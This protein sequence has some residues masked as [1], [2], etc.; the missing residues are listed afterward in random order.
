MSH[1]PPLSLES[2]GSWEKQDQFEDRGLVLRLPRFGFV[3]PG[4]DG[5]RGGETPEAA[6]V[7]RLGLS[8]P[9]LP[10]HSPPPLSLI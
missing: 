9:S 3:G 2:E 7:M 6:Y 8:P 5:N 1:N 10:P 4:E